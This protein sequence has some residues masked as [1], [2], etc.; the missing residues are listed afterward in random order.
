MAYLLPKKPTKLSESIM[1]V[2]YT[3]S[4]HRSSRYSHK[5]VQPQNRLSIKIRA[6]F[7][8]NYKAK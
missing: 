3:G 1:N 8:W 7:G 4:F 5:I 6:N 2:N